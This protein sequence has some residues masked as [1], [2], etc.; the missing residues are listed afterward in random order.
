VRLSTVKSNIHSRQCVGFE[1]M[2]DAKAAADAAKANEAAADDLLR[3]LCEKLAEKRMRAS[4]LFRK[5]DTSGD[6]SLE[7][8]ELREG[9]A[10]MGFRPSDEEFKLLMPRFD[11]DGGGDVSLRE[12]DRAIKDAE[13]LGPRKKKEAIVEVIPK[14]KQGLTA[15]DKEEF[16]QIFCLFKQLCRAETD[17]DGNELPMTD[18]D[19]SGTISIDEMEQLLETVG[20][21]VSP[22]ELQIMIAE[23]DKDGDGQINFQEFCDKMS[24]KVQVPYEPEDIGKAFKAFSHK[25]PDGLIRVEDLR[26]ALTTYMHKDL[27]PADVEDLLRYYKDCYVKVPGSDGEFFN[28]QD[29]IEIMTPLGQQG[30][31]G[32]D[33]E[34][35]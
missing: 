28:Y 8:S 4:D 21:K 17:E 26:N 33:A 7:A 5:I 18:F 15:E 1:A 9:F 22:E 14:K 31:G 35:S 25:A 2:A 6:G 27:T 29:Y 19:E 11:K 16:R 34:G 23:I 3:L 13:K 20:M 24:T 30:S 32:G 12:F 10:E